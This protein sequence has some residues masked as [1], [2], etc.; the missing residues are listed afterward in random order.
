M[1]S[2]GTP[3][4]T[5]AS[6]ASATKPL[7]LNFGLSTATKTTSAA[8]PTTGCFQGLSSITTSTSAAPPLSIP[9]KA[10]SPPDSKVDIKEDPV[11]PEIVKDVT[12]F[13]EYIKKEKEES[14][15]I[16]RFNTKPLHK[17]TDEVNQLSSTLA[18]ISSCY[19]RNISVV[20]KLRSDFSSELQNAEN[21]HITQ[22]M[23]P[24]MQL[25][26]ALPV[27]Y[28]QGQIEQF[29]ANMSSYQV[30]IDELEQHI[31]VLNNPSCLTAQ[32]ISSALSKMH[33]S[34]IALASNLHSVHSSVS[35]LKEQYLIYRRLVC[36]D[37]TDIFA[38][39]NKQKV[40]TGQ[41]TKPTSNDN[42]SN[43]VA[44]AMAS[45]MQQPTTAP[46]QQTFN[47]SA[48]PTATAN[49]G[50]LFGAKPATGGGLFG[51]TTGTANQTSSLFAAPNKTTNTLGGSKSLFGTTTTSASSGTTSTSS[52]G[53]LFGGG[54]A[55]SGGLFG[56]TTTTSSTSTLGNAFN[57]SAGLTF[58]GSAAGNKHPFDLKLPTNAKRNKS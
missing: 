47:P 2:F 45:V 17:I 18:T 28:F 51:S 19:K 12:A 5:T 56:T 1:F 33:D 55:S 13:K 10:V 43:A 23:T 34:F 16:A 52:A 50:G 29:E 44:L 14:N 57:S 54:A 7:S 32:D 8:V 58:G 42:L 40:E 37:T 24:T 25:D 21:A 11:P 6:S 36:G 38:A 20:K 15:E 53:T 4:S 26:N 41:R 3:S 39:K 48:A 35:R 31:N 30:Q 49:T 9:S 46:V 22:N 27:K